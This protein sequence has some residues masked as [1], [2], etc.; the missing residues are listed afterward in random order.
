M[1]DGPEYIA[2][3]D[4]DEGDTLIIEPGAG[5][6]S[7]TLS[8]GRVRVFA[9]G[10]EGAGG[11]GD[12][13]L[14]GTSRNDYLHGGDGNDTLHGGEGGDLLYG[15]GGNDYL[16]GDEGDDTLHGGPGSDYLAGGDGADTFVFNAGDVDHTPDLIQD[17]EP[18]VDTLEINDD[19]IT[20]ETWPGGQV[21][22]F[23]VSSAV[24]CQSD[25]PPFWF[26][27]I[28]DGDGL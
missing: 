14:H 3:F 6:Q 19:S 28:V 13:E 27:P 18:G 5:I 10:D 16:Y 26:E 9:E 2:D 23:K 12:L 7:E 21:R 1:D 22:V 11:E 24:S 4:A 20:S 8:D 15:Y 25:D 17:F